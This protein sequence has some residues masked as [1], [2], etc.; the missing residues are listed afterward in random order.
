MRGSDNEDIVRFYVNK[1]IPLTPFEWG[2]DFDFVVDM[3]IIF[4][5]YS[6]LEGRF[7]GVFNIKDGNNHNNM[8][9]FALT[10]ISCL[11]IQTVKRP[12]SSRPH[13]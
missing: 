1:N 11:F 6:L 8:K 2:V 10:L 7:R 5:I 13:Q 9:K 12:G 4:D 3:S